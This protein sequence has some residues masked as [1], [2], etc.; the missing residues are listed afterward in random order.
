MQRAKQLEKGK[1]LPNTF[2]AEYGN[3][4]KNLQRSIYQKRRKGS[5]ESEMIMLVKISEALNRKF[6]EQLK[7]KMVVKKT[8][9][10]SEIFGIILGVITTLTGIRSDELKLHRQF[11]RIIEARYIAMFCVR[12]VLDYS[13]DE[14][15]KMFGD[16][17]FHPSTVTSACRVIV[18]AIRYK[19]KY[20]YP[21]VAKTILSLRDEGINIDFDGE[22]PCWYEYLFDR[23]APNAYTLFRQRQMSSREVKFWK[24]RNAGNVA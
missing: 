2:N 17:P 14:L 1:F 24:M 20:L 23:S 9:T 21:L 18:N 12:W 16:K 11:A 7:E 8:L 13:N 6:E 5:E 3:Y 22:L 10:R 19:D 15:G 4:L